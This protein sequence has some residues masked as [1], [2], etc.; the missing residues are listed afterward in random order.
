MSDRAAQ[1][2]NEAA[3]A[4]PAAEGSLQ[5]SGLSCAK[6]QGWGTGLCVIVFSHLYRKY[7][8]VII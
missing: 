6:D 5:K 3:P 4:G 7:I 1:S 8:L 2:A